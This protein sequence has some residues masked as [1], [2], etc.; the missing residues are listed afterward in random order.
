MEVL[1]EDE[2]ENNKGFRDHTLII[3]KLRSFRRRYKKQDTP[4][5]IEAVKI[6][7]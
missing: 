6:I 1:F 2:L 3:L 7:A 4:V 5:T